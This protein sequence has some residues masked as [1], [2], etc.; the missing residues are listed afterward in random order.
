MRRDLE[1]V[2]TPDHV[3]LGYDAWAPVAR[4]D[5]KV[6]DERRVEWLSSLAR[7]KVPPDY[8]FAFERW[9]RALS[10][11][12]DRFAEFTLTSRLLVGHG[13]SSASD[14]GMTVHHT[15]GVPI[16][17]GSAL[18]GLLAH[19]L[20]ATYGPNNSDLEPWEQKGEELERVDF[21]GVTW[22]G[23]RPER[24]PGVI[25]RALFGAPDSQQD[26]AMRERGL[27]AG[28]SAGQVTFHDALFV[29]GSAENDKPFACDVL[30]VH[31][32]GYYDSC[33]SSAPNDYDSPNPVAFLTVRPKC[34]ILLA[35][36]GPS[37]WTELAGQ[38]LKQALETWGVGSKTSAG[39]GIGK[40]GAW[41]Q[42]ESPASPDLSEFEA[43]L[44]QAASQQS[45]Q[46][47]MLD[48]IETNWLP[49]LIP[50]SE[51]ER[52]RAANRITKSIRSPKLKSR[53]DALVRRVNEGRSS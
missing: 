41:Q 50:L 25:Y 11:P 17:P 47:P 2:G 46:R 5:G 35:L 52:K 28:Q 3:A 21:Q 42:P 53:L 34:R 45:Q 32:K 49:K 4:N 39:Y 8:G 15:W 51:D 14:I 33:G 19:Y 27:D 26:D 29:P 13:N 44:D 20:D 1:G 10:T 43:W 37:D 12:G 16:I 6:P 31:Q 36:S 24:G 30:T 7:V 40:V 48:D 23:R 18:K 9:K 22:R 38:L